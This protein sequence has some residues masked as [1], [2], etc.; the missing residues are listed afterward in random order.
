[1]KHRKNDNKHLQEVDKA[2][3]DAAKFAAGL[4]EAELHYLLMEGRAED[5]PEIRS[6]Y[7]KHFLIAMTRLLCKRC[8][9]SEKDARMQA[10]RSFAI[11][12]A[13]L[14]EKEKQLHRYDKNDADG[15]DKNNV[16][17]VKLYTEASRA[18]FLDASM[19]REPVRKVLRG[20]ISDEVLEE[21][22]DEVIDAYYVELLASLL[23]VKFDGMNTDTAERMASASLRSI[24]DEKINYV[25]APSE[26]FLS[27]HIA[28][29]VE[30]ISDDEALRL[31]NLAIDLVSPEDAEK[32]RKMMAAQNFAN[33][34]S[35]ESRMRHPP[36]GH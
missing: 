21:V 24:K 32:Y 33:R 4:V 13:D 27:R 30:N 25:R 7:V 11:F 23:L 2:A 1:M 36:S 28:D 15:Y 19:T 26:D 18:L 17:H 16:D 20:R 22:L 6:L 14:A 10:K 29:V 3:E 34:N 5:I 12:W 9:M 8:A 31:K 35:K